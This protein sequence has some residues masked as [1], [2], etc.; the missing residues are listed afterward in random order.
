MAQI[1]AQLGF[2]VVTLYNWRKTLH[3]QG[4]MVLASEKDPEGW[5]VTGKFTVV[6]DAAGLNA[7]EL[8]AYW[9]ER[10]LFPEQVAHWRQASLMPKKGQCLP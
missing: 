3:F 7:T 1:S 4:Q 8:S 6:L 5:R 9:R 10:D 2:H